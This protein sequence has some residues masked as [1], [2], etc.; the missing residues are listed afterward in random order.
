MKH[1]II[2]LFLLTSFF[3]CSSKSS[4]ESIAPA[5]AT[6]P[7]KATS[8]VATTS[9]A[10]TPDAVG[11]DLNGDGEPD[12]LEIR[13]TNREDRDLGKERDLVLYSGSGDERKDWYTAKNVLLPTEG[14]GLMGD[15]LQDASVVDNT[16]VIK[17]AGGSRQKWAYTHRFRWQNEDFQLVGITIQTDDPCDKIVNL[18]YDLTT[19]KAQWAKTTMDCSESEDNPSSS[20]A[21]YDF[22]LKSKELFSMNGFLTGENEMKV[23]NMGES[24]Y[25]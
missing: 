18:E 20:E 16:I 10:P 11:T 24:V 14:G 12:F 19:S 23:P 22:V 4:T 1:A 25:Y 7:T 2:F 3:T 15:P 13:M 6:V 17:H 9:V 8:P 5:T 21:V